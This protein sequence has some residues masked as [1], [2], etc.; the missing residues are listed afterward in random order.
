MTAGRV[1]LRVDS[2]A[3]HEASAS[4]RLADELTSRIVGDGDRLVRRHA[5]EG[6]P[7]ITGAWV[8][9]QFADGDPAALAMSDALVDELLSADELVLVAPVYNFGIPAAMK[10]WIDQVVRAGRTFRFTPEGP[11]GLAGSIRR[12]WIVSASG[13]TE[14]GSEFDFNTSYLRTVLQFIGVTDVRAIGAMGLQ[15][16]GEAAFADALADLEAQLVA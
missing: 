7:V 4:R 10:A 9:A 5:H 15:L 2:G 3:D 13:A 11:I 12:A 6:L 14:I 1:V 8:S 16:R